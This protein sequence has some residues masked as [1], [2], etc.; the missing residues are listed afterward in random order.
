MIDS[1]L[2]W[3]SPGG[4]VIRCRNA[5]DLASY[6]YPGL[7]RTRKKKK[8]RFLRVRGRLGYEATLDLEQ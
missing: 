1:R 4:A 2:L 6:M 3:V 5:L 8:K 7:P